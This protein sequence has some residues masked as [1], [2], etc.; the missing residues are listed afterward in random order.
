VAAAA[1]GTTAYR[2]LRSLELSG[3]TVEFAPSGAG[4]TG[5]ALRSG[6]DA[7]PVRLT[8]WGRDRGS[9]VLLLFEQ[10][11]ARMFPDYRPSR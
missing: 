11:C 6:H 1:E 10:A 5:L 8:A 3:W 9:V 7:G 2:L 4:L